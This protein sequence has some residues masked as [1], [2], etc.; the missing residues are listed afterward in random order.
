MTNYYRLYNVSS[1]VVV[2]GG[3]R[4][5]Y[6][7]TIGLS[8]TMV[9]FLFSVQTFAKLVFDIPTGLLA[10]FFGRK[11][12]IYLGL[13]AK[14]M[15]YFLLVFQP[16]LIGLMVAFILIGFSATCIEPTEDAFIHDVALT[17]KDDFLTLRSLFKKEQVF[18]NIAFNFL[19][20]FLYGINMQLPFM[21][22]IVLTLFSFI[23]FIFVSE[24]SAIDQKSKTLAFF[25]LDFKKLKANQNLNYAFVYGILFLT[26]IFLTISLKYPIMEAR[27]ISGSLVGYI[28]TSVQL[29]AFLALAYVQRIRDLCRDHI[30]EMAALVLVIGLIIAGTM[31]NFGLIILLITPFLYSLSQIDI[32]RRIADQ[33]GDM[34]KSTVLSAKDFMVSLFVML[35]LPLMGFLTDEYSIFF[36]SLFLALLLLIGLLFIKLI[37]KK[38]VFK[39]ELA[40]C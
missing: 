30:K 26:I 23:P 16:E 19:F 17:N 40:N 6:L 33:S 39:N 2:L 22:V 27:G 13:I 9:A 24:G 32:A 34:A 21:M 5:L 15:G 10:D 1:K 8:F 7:I 28:D 12:V 14:V 18:V 3:L 37:F 11:L 35:S 29:M 36:T 31:N 4:A 20:A 38:R 25:W